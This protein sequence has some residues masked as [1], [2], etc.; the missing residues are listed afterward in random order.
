MGVRAEF[1]V[2]LVRIVNEGLGKVRADEVWEIAA[3]LVVQ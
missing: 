2:D 1:Q 3:D